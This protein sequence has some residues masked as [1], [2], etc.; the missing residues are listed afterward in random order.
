MLTIGFA[1]RLRPLARL[2]VVLKT[3]FSPSVSTQTTLVCG[4]PSSPTVATT[5]KFLPFR[6]ARCLSVSS[7]ISLVPP[8][9]F[10]G[11]RDVRDL[12]ADDLLLQGGH[13]GRDALRRLG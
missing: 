13:L 4:L 8:R 6:S 2:F 12:P 5:P 11:R 3:T 1:R 7:A 9:L 10:H